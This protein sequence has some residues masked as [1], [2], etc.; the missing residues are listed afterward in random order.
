MLEKFSVGRLASLA[1]LLEVSA[2]KPGN[3][4]RGAD[5]A[6][7]TFEDFVVSAEVLGN[8]IDQDSELGVGETILAAVQATRAAVKTNTNLG[9]VLLMVPL[10]KAFAAT[11]ILTQT[12]V[13]ETLKS[14]DANDS[15]A[16]YAAINH[17]NAGGMSQTEDL[18]EMDLKSS[19]PDDLLAA[20]KNAA[21]RDMIALQYANGFQTVFDEVVPLLESAYQRESDL[22][23]AI[24]ESHVRLIAQYGDSLI[25]RKCG[26]S[27]SENARRMA[28][29]AI[30]RLDKN[31]QSEF[32]AAISDLDFWM[33]SDGNRRN[34]GT[35]A[36]LIAAGLFVGFA[37]GCFLPT[38]STSD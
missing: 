11:G 30:E 31:K 27:V 20:M 25:S 29:I 8:V 24:V 23:A 15:A 10:A 17:A 13:A 12:T 33:R 38:F 6:D 1:C 19:P 37:N 9:M 5:F 22:R 16:V 7:V 28:A 4:H 2:P 3:V 26:H 36:D 21:D 14:L 32:L 34:P 35:T 18:D